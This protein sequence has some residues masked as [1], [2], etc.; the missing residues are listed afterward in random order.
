MSTEHLGSWVVRSVNHGSPDEPFDVK[1]HSTEKA[2]RDDFDDRW[3]V[4]QAKGGA[5]ELLNPDGNWLQRVS[6][7]A[8]KGGG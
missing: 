1:P 3:R 8:P 7:P 4:I 6:K 5:C 2:A